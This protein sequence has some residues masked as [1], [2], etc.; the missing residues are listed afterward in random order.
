M[1]ATSLF[2]C[3]LCA[4]AAQA[5]DPY[6]AKVWD[7]TPAPGQ[8]VN[9]LPEYE[10]GDD[11]TAMAAKAL[12]Q[13]GGTE[14]GVITLGGF[15]GYIVF[16]FDHPV[17]NV[18]DQDDFT[19]T[20]NAHSGGAEPGIV[21]V[22]LDANA[23]GL[24]DDPWYQL[25]GSEYSNPDTD[26]N[27]SY[28]YVRA[29]QNW[30]TNQYHTQDYWPQ[31]IDAPSLTFTGE[32]LPDNATKEGSI[33]T[34]H[35]FAW[36][37]VDNQPGATPFRLDWAVD[38]DGQ[39]VDLPQADFIKVYNAMHQDCGWIGETSTEITGAQD[40]HPDAQASIPELKIDSE[41]PCYDLTGRRVDPSTARGLIISR[42]R[43]F[44]R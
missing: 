20:G 25:A 41:A 27:F 22:S 3:A 15:G 40:L 8:F 23:N 42:N 43:K 29:E 44:L 6:I 34:L 2:C 30:S 18:K 32:R 28:T 33:Y 11:A 5:A 4:L 26:H 21:M 17:V 7:Y 9:V 24:P 12:E 37:Y 36:G 35:P 31:W 38:A 19:I 39:P 16:G 14:G 1:K 13:I 10:E